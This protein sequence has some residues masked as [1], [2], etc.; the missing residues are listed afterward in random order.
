MRLSAC[1][2][3]VLTVVT[4]S[5]A[6]PITIWV[7]DFSTLDGVSTPDPNVEP[8]LYDGGAWVDGLGYCIMEVQMCDLQAEQAYDLTHG[9]LTV[10]L[11]VEGD[12]LF[13]DVASGV[14]LRFFSRTWNEDAGA[15]ELGGRQ[16]YYY[17]VENTSET[18]NF[19][20]GWQTFVRDLNDWD[21]TN[22]GGTF[23]SDQVYKFRLDS[24]PYGIPPYRLGISLCEIVAPECPNDL[25][26][27]D[28]V[29]L[30]D[31]ALLLSEYGCQASTTTL[32][33]SGG[34][35]SF[36]PGDLEGQDGWEA[37]C[38]AGLH[39]I[40][41]DPT[42]GDMGQILQL[43]AAYTDDLVAVQ[44]LLGVPV[45]DGAIIYDWDQYRPDLDENIWVCDDY[46]YDG[47][48]S[49]EWD[50]T[51]DVVPAPQWGGGIPL[52]ADIWQHIRFNLD[53][54]NETA[55]VN[56]DGGEPLSVGWTF[57]EINGIEFEIQGTDAGA[58]H[59]PVYL[60]NVVV[61]LREACPIDYDGDGDTDLADLAE[62]LAS[63]GCGVP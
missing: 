3:T 44:R 40:I 57:D 62:L 58:D 37:L 20:P 5:S 31:L 13:P 61:T 11:Q 1:L 63:Y 39:Q 42:G 49:L 28:D 9:E 16:E 12:G 51:G 18:Y 52:T 41:V 34:F 35:E 45:I 15:W 4:T 54:T 38:G 21:Q 2:L 8:Y 33:D 24:L 46:A 56:V 53:L 7:N 19:G 29:D 23:H 36:V 30:S 25:D 43:D 48:W 17:Q 32:Y 47:W 55:A 22:A 50:Q 6:T 14:W 59:G 60:D 10:E 27:D 26:G